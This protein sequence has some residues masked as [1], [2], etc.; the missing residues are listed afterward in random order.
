MSISNLKNGFRMRINTEKTGEQV[1]KALISHPMETGYR[2]D[3]KTEKNIP[4]DYIEDLYISVDGKKYFEIV[5]GENVS[6][7]PFLS[8]VF[9]KPL[10]DNQKFKI[11]WI[12]NNRRETSYECV[13]KF[14]QS[15]SFSYDDASKATEVEQATP[16]A[17]P[18]CK[19]KPP[20][21]AH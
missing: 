21:A 7:T 13:V 5:L 2:R 20:I 17:G 18:A 14:D 15:G 3:A 9:S 12:D 11:S 1:F 4:A 6:K 8:F 19:T 10:V 16:E